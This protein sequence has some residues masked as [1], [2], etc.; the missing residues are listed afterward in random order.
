MGML[1]HNEVFSKI[2]LGTKTKGIIKKIR[3]DGL[4]DV[5]LQAY[6]MKNLRD[7]SKTILQALKKYNGTRSIILFQ[8]L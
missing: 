8:S 1:Y 5:S 4:V 2:T 7:S 6:G 3:P